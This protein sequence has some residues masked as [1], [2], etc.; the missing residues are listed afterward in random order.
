MTLPVVVTTEIP[1]DP[2]YNLINHM[3]VEWTRCASVVAHDLPAYAIPF[4]G[5]AEDLSRIVAL[6]HD[7]T[8]RLLTLTGP[9]GIGKTRLA[10]EVARLMMDD[11]EVEAHGPPP[12]ETSLFADGTCFVPLQPLTS[13]DFIVPAIADALHF[14]FRGEVEP[15]QQLLGYLRGK[16]L[17]LVLD[18]F[19]HVAEGADLLPQM[20]EQAP[21]LKILVTSR[22][23]LHLREEWVFDVGGLTFPQQAHLEGWANFTAVQLFLQSARRAGYAP[24]EADIASIV[25]ICQVVEGIP[26]AVEL[27]AAWV[28]VMPCA[29][30]AR[31]V[32]HS[33]DILTTT[34]RNVP[35]KHRS[36]RAAFE[37]SWELL[38]D[39]EQAVFR[40]LSVF[41][42][43][44]SR[45]G[46]E[47]VAGATLAVLA[48]LVDQSLV[49][50]DTTG[51]YD[52]HELLRQYA[53]D[54]LLDT[55]EENTTIQRHCDYFLHLAERAEAHN[56]GR[57][58]V[59]WFDRLEDEFDN[60]RVALSRLAED[61]AGLQLAAALCWFFS[62]R[63][64]WNEGLM[65]L[66]R[67]L[68]ANPDAPASLR[69]KA[70]H[71]VGAQAGL[72]GDEQRARACCEQALALARS[73]NDRWNIAWSLCH[74]GLNAGYHPAQSAE[75]L[76]ESLALFRELDDPMG[77]AHTLIR[78]SWNAGTDYPYARRLTEEVATRARE[79]GDKMSAAWAA[80]S[81]GGLSWFQDHDLQQARAHF[82]NSLS[83]MRE[84]RFPDSAAL[85][86]LADV[87][88]ALGNVERAQTLYE[89]VLTQH[90]ESSTNN[91]NVT[92]VLA[93][94]AG[95]ARARGQ[96][97][98]AA[99]LLAHVDNIVSQF[100]ERDRADNVTF[101]K[102]VAAAREQLGEAAFAEAWAA[103]KAMTREQ[104]ITYA[105]ERPVTPTE[106]LDESDKV[107]SASPTR[108]E[109]LNARELEVLSLV[110]SGLSNRE[111]AGQLF[112]TVNTVKW[113]L[114]GIFGKL[115]VA[116]R[117]QAVARA[118]ALG[119]LSQE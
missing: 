2:V 17:L 64:Y 56:F 108:P 48:S 67:M 47:Q 103:G 75:L 111:I 19:E 65:W 82:E 25:R 85:Y 74:L 46:A 13:P 107:L 32:E 39:E 105:L 76:E 112:L 118:Q 16:H 15:K 52:L 43:G 113:Y 117:T 60:L 49:W 37:R 92:Y 110:A 41:R 22:E 98:W 34:L 66:E 84:A 91:V 50:V 29:G 28:R 53:A 87:E 10:I 40:Q 69:A 95:L 8:C 61:E 23:R 4:I 94:V 83:L 99:V 27:A 80:H 9:G 79:S 30:I 81:L 45:E 54:K 86:W 119:L 89:E 7:P 77:I 109:P 114:K 96:F 58:Q 90:R 1:G 57:E 78:L 38:T 72:L 55:G 11:D 24:A 71:S 63:G 100:P 44:F 21:A 3:H 59:A 116:N 12:L 88:R 5:R 62:E 70:L 42:G 115:Q 18:N 6:L 20:L 104:A 14:V 26:L 93:A 106:P 101:F 102:D 36:M 33:L 51:R 68:V 35:E 31:E 73:A 97:L